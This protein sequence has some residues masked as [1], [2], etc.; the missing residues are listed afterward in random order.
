MNCQKDNHWARVCCSRNQGGT[1]GRSRNRGNTRSCPR[2]RSRERRGRQRSASTNRRDQNASELSDQFETITFDSITVDAT[3]P[4]TQPTDEIF[5]T[6]NIDL[7][8][9]NKQ[10]T[11]LKAKLDTG[12]QGNILPLRLFRRMYLQRFSQG[13]SSRPLTYSAYG[14][15]RD[16]AGSIWQMQNPL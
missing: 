3:E 4:Q 10:P 1:H 5:A 7:D 2:S 13:R 14:L 12:A 11:A 16:K 6:I 8:T 15:W 9:T